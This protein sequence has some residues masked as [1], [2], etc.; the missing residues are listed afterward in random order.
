MFVVHVVALSADSSDKVHPSKRAQIAHL[1]ADK[2]STEVSSKYIDFVE[3][4]SSKLVTEL[5]KHG[6]NNH[7]IEFVDD[8]QPA[9]ALIYSL[10]PMKL[11]ILRAYIENN[12]ANGFIKPSKSPAGAPILFNKKLNG[13]LRFYIDYRGVNN[14]TIKNWYPLSL[15]RKLLN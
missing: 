11:E 6:I 14:L 7:I 5:L 10:G 13:R 2:A 1:K 3:V 15:V 8:W 9:Y 4:F 12:L